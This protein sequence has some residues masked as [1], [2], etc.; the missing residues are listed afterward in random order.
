M[1]AQYQPV[2]KTIAQIVDHSIKP[3]ARLAG[4]KK[5]GLHFHGRNGELVHVI[6]IQLSQYNFGA[7]GGF[8]V[9]IG[10]AFDKLYALRRLPINPKPSAHTCHFHRRIE[11]FCSDAPDEWHI[12]ESTDFEE[13]TAQLARNFSS[14]LE[15]LDGVNSIS[16]FLAR[17]WLKTGSDYGLLAQ[18][19]YVLGDIVAARQAIQRE[20]EYFADRRGMS[21]PELIARYHLTLLASDGV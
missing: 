1:T 6:T 10:I 7:T 4:F 13:M 17:N 19:R 16:E 12:S 21:V 15:A 20:S 9:N 8:S 14:V 3:Q 18:L 5:T 11:F 2:R